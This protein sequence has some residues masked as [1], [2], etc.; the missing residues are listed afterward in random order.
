MVVKDNPV[1]GFFYLMLDS[2]SISCCFFL[3]IECYAVLQNAFKPNAAAKLL[4]QMKTG[5]YKIYL[6]FVLAVHPG[7]LESFGYFH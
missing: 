6:V 1:I 7:I 3:R 2:C 4:F 5:N